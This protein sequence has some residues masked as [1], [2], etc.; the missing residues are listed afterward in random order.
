MSLFKGRPGHQLLSG[1]KA[2][3]T[4]KT[5]LDQRE[6]RHNVAP[7]RPSPRCMA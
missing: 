2:L 1:S 5:S 4:Q 6:R 3:R 7:Q